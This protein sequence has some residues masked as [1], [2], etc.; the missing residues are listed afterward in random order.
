M[1]AYTRANNAYAYAGSAHSKVGTVKESLTYISQSLAK[2]SSG[3]SH[4]YQLTTHS[5][6]HYINANGEVVS[7]NDFS[8]YDCDYTLQAGDLCS[9]YIGGGVLE[10]IQNANISVVSKVHTKH[11]TNTNTYPTLRHAPLYVRNFADLQILPSY[12]TE[13]MILTN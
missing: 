1:C 4:T 12:A 7:S 13:N 10:Q 8:I 3:F 6:R 5:S 11:N 9:V 2:Y